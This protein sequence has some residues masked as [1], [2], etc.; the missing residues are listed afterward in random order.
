LGIRK[1]VMSSKETEFKIF[2][3]KSIKKV[4]NPL[5]R[6]LSFNVRI[7]MRISK[8]VPIMI[9]LSLMMLNIDPLGNEAEAIPPIDTDQGMFIEVLLNKNDIGYDLKPLK[10]LVEDGYVNKVESE[11][12]FPYMD[13]LSDVM[14][15]PMGPSE[16]YVYK[17]HT[18]E[19]LGVMVYETDNSFLSLITGV[20]MDLRGLSVALT[21]PTKVE[22]ISFTEFQRII[23]I[24]DD[25][26]INPS[27]VDFMNGLGYFGGPIEI[28]VI[29]GS[30]EIWMYSFHS[31]NF[32]INIILDDDDPST[33]I[34]N[35]WTVQLVGMNVTLNEPVKEDTQDLL[36]FLGL[37]TSR[38]GLGKNFTTYQVMDMITPDTELDLENFEWGNAMEQ[39]LKFLRNLSVIKDLDDDDIEEIVS[40]IGPGKLAL[41][42]IIL[43][44]LGSWT[45]FRDLLTDSIL[46][47]WPAPMISKVHVPAKSI[48]NDLHADGSD[49]RRR[50]IFGTLI[51]SFI[52][53]TMM[54]SV[55][56]FTRLKTRS[57]TNNANR[58]RIIDLIGRSPGI[59]FRELSRELDLK[60]GVL[61]YHM[62][63]LEEHEIIKSIQDG[64]L[65]RFY[66]FND[67]IEPKVTLS[68]IQ[69]R[70]IGIIYEQP[71]ISQS[72]IS[73]KMGKSKA[74]IN[75][76]IRILQNTGL[77]NIE[78]E[79]G[80]TKCYIDRDLRIL[81][82]S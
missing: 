65:R 14:P 77:I 43:F 40:N 70:M 25:T 27:I 31:G 17:S 67:K 52:V 4:P 59:H 46:G 13:D 82:I 9:T 57:L 8:T 7:K 42:D 36:Q 53:L 56:I 54:G 75:Y 45:S 12:L 62:N 61:S 18:S 26:D 44:H 21:I 29:P 32:S 39:E 35:N 11:D 10:K 49:L 80:I 81:V 66:L 58:S 55:A 41:N 16:Y 6:T 2:L 1:E 38:W 78:K 28:S 23:P 64:N 19:E 73:K 79:S 60:Q 71:G 47:M 72:S 15:F 24:P 51:V 5:I 50:I 33:T 37:N 76:H 48:P 63:I 30:S 68:E 3:N 69:E 20:E 34:D 74:L 22:T